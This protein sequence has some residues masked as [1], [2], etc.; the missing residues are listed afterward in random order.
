MYFCNRFLVP[1][2]FF[3]FFTNYLC[4]SKMQKEEICLKEEFNKPSKK[5]NFVLGLCCLSLLIFTVYQRESDEVPVQLKDQFNPESLILNF[6]ATYS[7][8]FICTFFHELGHGLA[9][10][11]LTGRIFNIHL[12]AGADDDPITLFECKGVYLDGFDPLVGFTKH[13]ESKE[14]RKAVLKAYKEF[15]VSHQRELIDLNDDEIAKRFVESNELKTVLAEFKISDRNKVLINLAG[16]MCGIGA[17]FLIKM[18]FGFVSNMIEQKEDNFLSNFRLALKKA[19]SLDQ[20]YVNQ[21]FNMLVPMNY[22][23]NVRGD[24]VEVW[25]A[26][27]CSEGL[28]KGVSYLEPY[29]LMLVF[30]GLIFRDSGEKENRLFFDKVLIG[31][32]NFFLQGYL[33]F[34]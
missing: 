7:M 33:N 2:L 10:K 4:F 22:S 1:I 5:L 24:A 20:I 17:N 19:F 11:F 26:L 9:S 32:T 34:N 25:R 3:T 27:G 31:L 8:N 28:I 23:N 21:L 14:F 18:V 15:F 6:L 30:V 29:L 12:G 13:F 16:G